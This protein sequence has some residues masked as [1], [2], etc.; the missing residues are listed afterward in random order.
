MTDSNKYNGWTNFDTWRVKLEHVDNM[1][2]DEFDN[3]NTVKEIGERLKECIQS[4][5]FD[6]PG[7]WSKDY[8]DAF[9]DD[10]NWSEL[11]AHMND[12]YRY[13]RVAV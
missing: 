11:A 7:D 12:A 10:V 4:L 8:T 5:I 13:D 2:W 9:M 3:G 6:N 1:T